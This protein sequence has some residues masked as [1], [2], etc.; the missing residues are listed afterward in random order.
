MSF[1][2]HSIEGFGKPGFSAILKTHR[3]KE[4]M[5]RKIDDTV[6]EYGAPRAT[7]TTGL[8]PEILARL[9]GIRMD[10]P[11]KDKS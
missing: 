11:L 8:K 2:N 5:T 7:D 1:D 9:I 4:V 6:D 10:A 3:R